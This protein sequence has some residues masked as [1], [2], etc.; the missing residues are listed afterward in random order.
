MAEVIRVGMAELKVGK[1][2][3]KIVTLGL[4]SCIG[5]C[6]YDALLKVGGIVHIMLPD[7]SMAIEPINP[8]KFADTGIPLL[9]HEMEQQGAMFTRIIIKIVGGAEM[10][11]ANNYDAHL[12]VG[13]RNVLAVE[14]TCHKLNLAIAAKSTG[15][16]AGKSVNFNLDT[17][18]IEVKSM[19]STLILL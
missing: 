12:G 15:G 8:A 3:D 13:E 19:N 17:G 2:P 14:E 11:S 18:V 6:T 9:L 4:G 7:S 10:F 5:V 16:H 1:A